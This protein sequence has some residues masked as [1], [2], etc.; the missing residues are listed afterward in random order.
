M[1][2][3]PPS[4]YAVKRTAGGFGVYYEVGAVSALV[5]E[6]ATH[7][8]AASCAADLSA[9]PIAPGGGLTTHEAAG[10]HTLAGHAG[11]SLQELQTRLGA[12]PK[13][14]AVSTLADPGVADRVVAEALAN[15]VNA[16]DVSTWLAKGPSGHPKA[17][18]M[19]D[20]GRPVGS[21]LR[22][23]AAGVVA[24]SVVKVILQRDANCP[25]GYFV[26]TV[27]LER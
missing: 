5:G 8:E 24:G 3:Q 19:Q 1:A 10:G 11:K 16:N 27:R 9:S 26:Q 23:G 21:I 18:L 20:C 22:R 4:D 7:P 15:P 12:D 14:S 2:T 6:F 25:L 13:L 17:A